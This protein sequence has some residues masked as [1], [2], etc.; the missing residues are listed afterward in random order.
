MLIFFFP[1][2]FLEKTKHAV[3][4]W[5]HPTTGICNLAILPTRRDAQTASLPIKTNAAKQTAETES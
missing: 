4:S 3:A 2:L 1:L 5:C